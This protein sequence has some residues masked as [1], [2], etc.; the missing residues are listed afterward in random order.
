L[1]PQRHIPRNVL[2][3]GDGGLGDGH[4]QV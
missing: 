1:F 3:A 4:D 2:E